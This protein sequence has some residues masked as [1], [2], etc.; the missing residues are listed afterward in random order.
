[1]N[2][3]RRAAALAALCA[4]LCACGKP[5]PPATYQRPNVLL[6]T[7]D[8]VRAD[9]LGCYGCE[10]DTSPRLDRLAAE[11]LRFSAAYAQSSFTP[12]SH[13]SLFSARHVASHGVA[14]W[15]HRLPAEVVTLAEVLRD[16]GYCTASFSP[17]ALGS[18]NGLD[19]GF[20]RVVEMRDEGDWTLPLD[21]DRGNDVRFAPAAAINERFASWLAEPR[22][23]PFFA[24]VHYYDAH[25]PYAAFAPERAF[26]ARRDEPFGNSQRDYR[27]TPEE[28][29]ARA[30][31]PEEARVLKD[32]YDSGLLALDRELGRLLDAV[33]ASGLAG[34]TLVIVTADHG[35]AFD[36]FAEE[37]FTHDPLLHDAVTHVPLIVRFPDR[38][39][40]GRTVDRLAQLI[41]VAPTL[42]DYLGLPAPFGMQGRSL[43]PAIEDGVEV[44]A[45]AA[46]ERAG[47]DSDPRAP[48]RA[49]SPEEIGLRRSLRFPSWRLVVEVA[50]GESRLFERAGSA[51][52]RA[53]VRDEHPEEAA[54]A[55][56]AYLEHVRGIEALTPRTDVRALGPEERRML[57][58]LGYL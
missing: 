43:R 8:T 22:D 51:P 29:R 10:R 49:F 39:L 55:R 37:W 20:E 13:A 14:W 2:A 16:A 36:E 15:H 54:A 6:V 30:I 42:F 5:E 25:R 41:D 47:R 46:S 32:R 28:R 48:E 52:E 1:M 33:E 24:W 18:Q 9:R 57:E 45:F 44:N 23:R 12:P 50:S 40:A 4:A 11:S 21:E 19:Q 38:R 31:G 17:L 7:L 3:R 53:D 35:E 58:E 26:C 27:L 56:Q 34:D